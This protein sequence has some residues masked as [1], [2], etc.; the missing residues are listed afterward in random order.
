MTCLHECFADLDLSLSIVSETWINAAK[1]SDRAATRLEMQ[2]GLEIIHKSR[3]NRNGGGV[4]IIFDS[5]KVT[6]K[7]VP[8]ESR[9]EIVIA[10]GKIKRACRTLCVVSVYLPPDLSA[11]AICDAILD[12]GR[13]VTK[14]REK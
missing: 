7:R 8:F 5:N 11:M 9:F 10:F 1:D 3:R 12:I 14:I 4:A 13:A 6:M 2:C